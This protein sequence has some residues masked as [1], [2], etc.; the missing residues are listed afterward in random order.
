MITDRSKLETVSIIIPVY[1][2]EKYMVGL[3]NS[4]H[5]Q[6]YD[7]EKIEVIFVDG[8]S[9]DRTIEIINQKM[10]KSNIDY[11]VISNPK[12]NPPSSVNIGIKNSKNDIIVRL[13]A[14]SEYPTN[15]ISKCVYYLNNIEA[16]NVGC[17]CKASSNT[18]VGKSIAYVVSSKFGVGNSSFR[19]NSKNGY[20]DTVPFG[21]FRTK[22][23]DIIGYFDEELPRSEDNEFNY[24]IRKNGGKIYLFN[25]VEVVYYSRD[26]I[27]KL[28]KMGFQ[29]GK[30]TTYTGYIIPGSI[31]IRHFIPLL[32]VIGLIIGVIITLLK[33]KIL[34]IVFFSILTIY[35]I[36]D[37]IFTIKAI[38]N[39]GI[40]RFLCF[41]I[42]PLFHISYGIGSIF[43]IFKIIKRKLKSKQ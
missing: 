23:F 42:Y 22:L 17:I 37:L 28:L 19:I 3:I 11:V 16:D 14:H 33:F 39:N 21:T 5:N 9:N 4:L 2:E 15:Y 35:L 43:G 12:K 27:I 30:W 36:I 34:T 24:R 25:D 41:I 18:S 10:L 32:F 40:G 29:N 31:G 7:K 1:N 6:D 26:T 8:I 13:D 20:V 38:I